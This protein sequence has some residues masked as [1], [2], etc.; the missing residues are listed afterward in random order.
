MST[1]PPLSAERPLSGAAKATL[2]VS[3]S[4]VI[5]L[6]YASYLAAMLLLLLLL[7]CETILAIAGA[8][9]G[10]AGF[11]INMMKRQTPLLGILYRSFWLGQGTDYRIAIQSKDAPKLF[12]LLGDLSARL[13]IAPPDEVSIEM[14]SGAWVRLPGLRRGAGKTILGIGYDLLAGLSISEVE[15]VMA[16]E[17]THAKLVQR[18]LKQWLNAG[19]ARTV[20]VASGLSQMVDAGRQAKQASTLA[21]LFL[22]CAGPLASL[23]AR[24]VAKYS[25]QDEFEA[26]RGAA[27]LCGAEPLRTS[28]QRLEA[29]E[30]KL[31]R[32]P[33]PE[34]VA[35][36]QL[37][38]SFSQWLIRELSTPTSSREHAIRTTVHDPF[39]T[40]PSLHDR[41][42]ALPASTSARRDE[43]SGIQLLAAPDQIADRLMTEI[44]RVVAEQEQKDTQTISKWAR[45]TQRSTSIQIRWQ[46][47]PSIP[48]MFLGIIFGVVT[49]A[50][51]FNPISAL[52]AL[53]LGAAAVWSWRLGRYKDNRT[54]PVPSFSDLK[55]AWQAEAPPNLA[56]REKQLESE[57]TKTIAAETKK[58]RQIAV[59][60][61][62]GYAA[63][64][65]C[66]YLSAH[67]ATRLALDRD[68]KSIEAALGMAI[69]AAGLQFYD[70]TGAM[71]GF[72]R[73][74]VGFHT[75]AT[76]WGAA[77]AL[78][79]LGDWEHAE[80]MLWRKHEQD[81]A[82][83]TFLALLALAQLR[84]NK[85]QSAAANT[86]RAL[87]IDGNQTAV[88]TLLV[89]TL[90]D[91]GRLRDAARHLEQLEPLARG[92]TELALLQVR[93]NLL[94][95]R[96][97]LARQWAA[98]LRANDASPK[99]LI[100]LGTL[101]QNARLDD[102][103]GSFLHEALQVG[104][105][106]ESHLE[107]ARLAT[108]RRDTAVARSHLL[109]ALNV[110]KKLG[111]KATGPL[112]LF[113]HTLAA[114]IQQEEPRSDCRAWI[115]TF[116]SGEPP[117]TPAALSK[118]SFF[119]YAPDQTAAE[120][121]A[122]TILVSM[123]PTNPP[124]RAATLH[125]KPAPK[126][127]QPVRPVRPGVEYVL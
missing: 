126:D 123:Q 127:Q 35:Q 120:N 53:V 86:T 47:L 124:A 20:R 58:R 125:W 96:F 121:Y 69:A 18:G 10:M 13:Q 9:F 99:W 94:R 98:T 34:R 80:A 122:D 71:L 76:L 30:E 75:P 22:H 117:T 68:G 100:R 50:D 44:Q 103:A 78:T 51:G 67:V 62:H 114:L 61:D 39:S 63:L 16:H 92:D 19:L 37:D 83:T 15:A 42:A 113:H 8:R 6:C 72:V 81:P 21:T 46:Q 40:H 101:F 115:A 112:P 48:L 97:D 65:R 89:E 119:I 14:N 93:L 107:L 1:P 116:P 12:A 45:K 118:R 23:A 82:N 74:K 90:L 66:D 31:A 70:Q 64:G 87:A 59:L 60:L 108:S 25:R 110:E 17:M 27:E 105:Y 91:A 33:W 85:L 24:L 111:E 57:L 38:E 41:I 79:L 29:M 77:W 49:F 43:E 2:V 28:L 4:S 88:V 56:E 52:T 73:D 104:H 5:L 7:A 32:L 26:D 55:R 84:R 3:A 36:L 109:A 106:P 102:D 95:R 11:V 54:L